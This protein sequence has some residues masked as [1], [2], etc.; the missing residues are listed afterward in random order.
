VFWS[1]RSCTNGVDLVCAPPSQFT[2]N[3]PP[4][5]LEVCMGALHKCSVGE[6][7]PHQV[8]QLVTWWFFPT[9]ETHGRICWWMNNGVHPATQTERISVLDEN[10]SLCALR[11][12]HIGTP[13]V[14]AP[15]TKVHSGGTER[16]SEQHRARTL[17]RIEV[18]KW[19]Y[20][21]HWSKELACA[22]VA[23]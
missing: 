15:W 21:L 13:V 8:P 20:E 5:Q 11:W 18:E 23:C 6:N 12:V 7:W 1:I 4:P 22:S 19:G 9:T 2:K 17:W 16:G 10:R 14:A 3:R